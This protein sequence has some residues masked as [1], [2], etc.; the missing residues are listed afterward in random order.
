M[1]SP[2]G[3]SAIDDQ[4]SA[5]VKLELSPSVMSNTTNIQKL[6]YSGDGGES[7]LNSSNLTRAKLQ[8]ETSLVSSEKASEA[9]MKVIREDQSSEVSQSE[10]MIKVEGGYDSEEDQDYLKNYQS[11]HQK[12]FQPPLSTKIPMMGGSF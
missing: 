10:K 11:P 6:E 9:L 4:S 7:E 1:I 5:V 2:S 8:R 12:E 3:V